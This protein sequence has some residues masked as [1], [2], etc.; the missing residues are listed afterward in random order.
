MST[1]L[2]II[3]KFSFKFKNSKNTAKLIQDDLQFCNKLKIFF[4]IE[5]LMRRLFLLVIKVI[6]QQ[7]AKGADYLP[8]RSNNS[9]EISIYKGFLFF[10]LFPIKKNINYLLKKTFS[11]KKTEIVK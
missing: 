3:E 10:I 7:F 4:Y 8:N 5:L 2:G 1:I 9:D 11:P 6:Q